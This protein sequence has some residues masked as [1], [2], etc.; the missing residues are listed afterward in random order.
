MAYG[1]PGHAH[2]RLNR[3]DP[4]Q[5]PEPCVQRDPGAIVMDFAKC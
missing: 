1:N 2:S 5:E 4:E 3:H